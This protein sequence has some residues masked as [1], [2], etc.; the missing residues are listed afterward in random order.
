MKRVFIIHGW[1]G[2][3]QNDFLPWLGKEFEKFGYQ[4]FIPD[5]PDTE[6]PVIEKW[7][8]HLSEI[9]GIPDEQS[10]FIGHSIGCQTILRYLESV[11]VEVGGAVF[12]AGWFKLENLEVEDAEDE[13][14]KEVA[15]P[16]IET[17]INLKK[18]AKALPKSTLI[19]SD[20]DP[21][22]AFEENKKKF[23]E[24]GS[25]I[26]VL[27]NAGHITADDGFSEAPVISKEFQKLAA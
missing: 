19:I 6:T 22:G 12:V 18:V 17:S 14:A 26:L 2:G 10:F 11:K 25:K 9:V 23:R 7:V 20:N 27:H 24:L 8:K 5:M 16:W 15:R 13:D 3:P 1:G 4:V 21:Y